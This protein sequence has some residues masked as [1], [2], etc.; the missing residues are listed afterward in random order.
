MTDDGNAAADAHAPRAED[1]P[2]DEDVDEGGYRQLPDRV[3]LEE[4]VAAQ[5]PRPVPGPTLGRDPDLD[6]MLRYAG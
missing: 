6:F 2:R 1:A 4:T 5:D 3:R